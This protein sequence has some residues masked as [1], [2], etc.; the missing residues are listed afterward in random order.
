MKTPQLI[1][2]AWDHDVDPKMRDQI[3]TI[4]MD[5]ER[6]LGVEGGGDEA[7]P[8]GPMA[9][10]EEMAGL[11]PDPADPQ[12][13]ARLFAKREFYEARALAA[14]IAS[15]TVNMCTSQ[16][17]TKLF[18]LTPVQRIVSRFLHPL[19]PY[20]GLLLFHGVGVGKTCSAVTIA[21]QFLE[22]APGQKVIVLVPQALKDN[23]KNTVFDSA[24]LVWNTEEGRW[25]SQQCTGTS[26]L[27]RLGLLENPDLKAVSFK[28]EEDKRARYTVTGYAAFANWIERSLEKRIPIGLKDAAARRSLEDD[29]L[30]QL[31]SDHLIIVDEAHNLRDTSE[32]GPGAADA[33][34][35]GEAAENAGGK[36]LNPLLKRIVLNAEGLRMVLMTATP[37]YN[38][39]PEIVLLLNYLLMNDSKKETSQ[40]RI[41]DLFSKDGFLNPGAPQRALER[42]ARR[43]VSYMRG[44]NPY[45]FPL[46]M[47]PAVAAANP[48]SLWP[49]VS[50]TKRD[51]DFTEEEAA[52]IG[53]LPLVFT[54]PV[55]DSPPER[56]LRGGSR[57][58]VEEGDLKKSDAMLDLRMQM[59][60]ISYSNGTYGTPGWDT[61]FASQIQLGGPQRLR[62]F[63]PKPG[64]DVDSVFQGE[65]LRAHAPKM[66]RVV[67]SIK[68][69][70]GICFV[71]SRYLKAGAL[72]MAVA[73]ERAGYQ[74]RMADGRLAPLLTGVA[75]VPPV[76]ALCGLNDGASHGPGPD[77][78]E[79]KPA[80]Y[81]LLTSQDEYSPLFKGIVKQASTWREDP[82]DGPLGSRV[83]V[84]LGS[85]V[86][87]EGLDL[88]CVREMHILDSWYH[89]NRTEQIIGRA[90]RFRS[91]AGLCCPDGPN[92]SVE[93]RLGLPPM[94]L[95]NCLVYLHAL[96]VP[97]VEGGPPGFETA[98]MYAYRIAIG[99]AR[100]VGQVQRLLKKNAWDCNLELE[101]ISF[102]DL[103]PRVQVDAQGRRQEEYSINDQ[104]YTTYC[105]YA[106]CEHKCAVTVVAEGLHLDSSTFRVEDARR[107][108]LA[109]QSLVRAFFKD[110]VMIPE[111]T[112]RDV[113]S[114]LPWEIASEA[115]MEL[116][117]G[118]RFRL[119]RDGLEGFLVKK[120]GYLVFQPAAITELDIPLSMR[121]S[122]GFQ[123][124]RRFMETRLPVL[125]RGEVR[126]VAAASV[127]APVGNS[128]ASSAVAA[129][130]PASPLK[131]WTQWVS[132][133]NGEGPL[134]ADA[135]PMWSWLM[136]RYAAIPEVRMVALTW[137]VEKHLGTA[138]LRNAF[139]QVIRG[140]ADPELTAVLAPHILKAKDINVYRIYNP[141]DMAVEYQCLDAGSGTFKTCDSGIKAAVEKEFA[142]RQG[143]LERGS[144]LGFYAAKAGKLVFKTFD[145]TKPKTPSAVG[146]EC[147]N[148]SNLQQH[149]PLIVDHL[150]PV[151]RTDA[152]LAPLMLPDDGDLKLKAGEKKNPN[153]PTHLK[154]IT[155]QPLCLY[156]EFLT[157]LFDARRI[158]GRRW[159]FD[160][161]TASI[162]G[163]KG[164][165]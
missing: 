127:A 49:A 141:S 101:A 32:D 155:H 98:D 128:S 161:V 38:S 40:L 151:G 156:I 61:V 147:G 62:V 134:P 107:L 27:E 103:P 85:Q 149:Q 17:V 109:K 89:L 115:L 24:D 57:E 119:S 110:Q 91:H 94:S 158:Q 58:E 163:L 36:K 132:F 69:A 68:S 162:A 137:W 71:Y 160:A 97:D 47:R 104:D 120:A 131:G 50:A 4:M 126:P 145:M 142:R 118:R 72:P 148:T 43:Y 23:F 64:F 14:G 112:V 15:G 75:R 65:G 130:A 106:V 88:K 37:M 77:S 100:A 22:S 54:E 74:R 84:I 99:K 165:K 102:I 18:E 26:Y 76:C 44:E 63:M 13:A 80:C 7:W 81:V 154:D 111:T 105:D 9:A 12:F 39:A 6:R 8:S 153:A 56:M 41:A 83:K 35:T 117:D 52:A 157:R 25:Y 45:T 79:F 87:S 108:V 140:L 136:T 90:I 93:T 129:P 2:E 33:V 143:P 124:Q 11:Y 150:H 164:R 48:A 60:N 53:A 78:H 5:R 123:L 73:L 34:A 92:P 95:N 152:D 114:D 122:R 42:A 46:R 29:I 3:V 113:F 59:A 30:R 146:A 133:V 70:R 51:V 125:L 20:Q 135:L 144:L 139:E 31:F 66:H 67:E 138:E 55:P 96:H 86:A 121:Y 10:R 16:A 19:T 1:S 159:F 21:E 82:V 28:V 116:L